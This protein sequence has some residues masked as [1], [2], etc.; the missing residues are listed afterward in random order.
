VREDYRSAPLST[1]DRAM[2]DFAVKLTLAPKSMRQD[3]VQ[4]LRN[5]GF[6][7][8]AIHDIVQI[9]ALFNYY[10]RLADGLGIELEPEWS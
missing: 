7:D 9:A 3:D 2:L 10:N 5:A 8:E 1:A 4:T 6:T